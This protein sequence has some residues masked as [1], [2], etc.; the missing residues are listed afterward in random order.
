MSIVLRKIA[1]R[2]MDAR[3]VEVLR[4]MESRM[5]T[6][7]HGFVCCGRFVMVSSQIH[8]VIASVFICVYPWFLLFFVFSESPEFFAVDVDSRCRGAVFLTVAMPDLNLGTC[9]VL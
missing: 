2:I 7:E 4:K 1:G 8:F 5:N 9:A 3:R 6:D